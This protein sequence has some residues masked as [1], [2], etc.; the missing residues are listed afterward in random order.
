MIA[1]RFGNKLKLP[2]TAQLKRQLLLMWLADQTKREAVEAS[3]PKTG[4][5]SVPI[6]VHDA[7]F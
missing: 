1:T 5:G 3:K 2:S 7:A 4:T 6:H